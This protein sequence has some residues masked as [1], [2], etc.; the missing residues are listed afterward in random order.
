M[1]YR[2][3]TGQVGVV[4]DWNTSDGDLTPIRCIKNLP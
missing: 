1:P 2:W 4:G 3:N